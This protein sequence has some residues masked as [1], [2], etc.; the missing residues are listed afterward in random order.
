[1]ATPLTAETVTVPPS[2]DPPGLLERAMVTAPPNDEAIRPEAS[3]AVTVRLKGDPAATLDGG[4]AVTTSWVA[5]GAVT[6]TAEVVAA[7]SPPPLAWIV[8]PLPTWF[9]VSPEKVAIPLTAVAVSVPPSD[10]PPE[11]PDRVRAT[12]PLKEEAML[13][14]PSSADTVR[15]NGAPATTA[16]GGWALTTN[17]VGTTGVGK[18]AAMCPFVV[19][20]GATVFRCDP[21]GEYSSSELDVRA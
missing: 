16:P 2:V 10:A 6:F 5:M 7:V 18:M 12:V 3:S 19:S 13:P 8:Y 9:R 14:E 21:E 15:P 20:D 4:C 1:M 11:P 17:W